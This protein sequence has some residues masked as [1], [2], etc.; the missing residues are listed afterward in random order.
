MGK[1]TATKIK[2]IKEAGRYGDGDGLA[3]VVK[4][5]G[6]SSWVVRVQ[7]DKKSRDFGLGSLKKISLADARLKAQEIRSQI[8]SGIDPITQKQKSNA[9]PTFREAAYIVYEEQRQ[10]W[11]NAKHNKQWITTLETYAFPIV[12]D[13]TVDKVE[14]SMVYDILLENWLTKH[15]TMRRVRQRI[16]TVIDW[17]VT[18]E[19]RDHPLPMHII[20]KSLPKR[21]RQNGHYSAMPYI[22]VPVFY[23]GTHNKTGI[24]ALALKFTILCAARSGETRNATW[25]EIDFDECLWIIPED[26]MKAARAHTVPL[27]NQAINILKQIKAMGF[28]SN[29]L[30]FKGTKKDKPL[31]DM[32][33]TKIVRDAG[34]SFTVHGFRSSFKDWAAEETDYANEVSE[35]ALAHKIAN[36][37]EAAYRRGT[38][39][40]KRRTLMNDWADYVCGQSD[41]VRVAG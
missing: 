29:D 23:K 34:L 1:L 10:V 33:L 28:E 8:E 27:S 17:A 26:R 37:T 22:D 7:K 14:R 32:T 20:N 18:K 21:N 19:Y 15:E 35:M 30:I 4:K 25:Q 6:A 24:G 9:I 31:S 39:L 16:N 11:K 5:S 36:A 12:G 13:I 40:D 38:L 2:A 3:L 41:I